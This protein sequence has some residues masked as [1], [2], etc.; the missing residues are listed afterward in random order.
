MKKLEGISTA[1]VTPFKEGMIDFEGF[2][3]LLAY[4]I[5]G[6]INA[7]L[8]SGT[9]GEAPSLTREERVLLIRR[10]KEYCR[11]RVFVIAGVGTNSTKTSVEYAKD[12]AESG[13]DALLA[14]VPYY[15][16]P[17]EEGL[18]RHFEAIAKTVEL[19]LILYNVPSRTGMEMPIEAI[20]RLAKLKNVVALKEAS[21]NLERISEV[22]SK[23]EITILSGNDSLA[24]PSFALGAEGV[25][26][27]VSNVAPKEMR[28]MWEHYMN[29][30][31]EGALKTH[32]KLFRLMRALFVETNPIPVKAALSI[33]GLCSDEVRL[34]LAPASA[35]TRE[36]LKRELAA[37]GLL[38]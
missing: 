13:A 24:L 20:A 21:T 23:S 37:L 9:T 30:D 16:K 35:A 27:V 22:R 33:M 2:E 4:Q 38:C 34:P 1:L 15:N 12:A 29:G 18:Y 28:A 32:Q 5:E 25:I 14:V 19:P 8:V 7:V 36:L 6:G 3:R 17:N 10:A 11:G 31:T 26:S